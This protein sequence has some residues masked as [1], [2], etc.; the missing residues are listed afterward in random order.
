MPVPG[1]RDRDLVVRYDFDGDIEWIY[2]VLDVARSKNFGRFNT[3]QT[4]KL[5]R[6]DKTDIVYT[7]PFIETKVTF[8]P[9]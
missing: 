8:L 3:Q 5:Q 4:I 7:L 1:I 9:S 2:E 6:L